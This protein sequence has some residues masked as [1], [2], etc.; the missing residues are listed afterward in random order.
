MKS[1]QV[2][3]SLRGGPVGTPF[4]LL[5]FMNAKKCTIFQDFAYTISKNFPGVIPRAPASVPG[6]W[7]QTPIS[8]GVASVPIV[9]VFAKRDHCSRAVFAEFV[10]G[11]F[12]F[13]HLERGSRRR[14]VVA[15]LRRAGRRQERHRPAGRRQQPLAIAGDAPQSNDDEHVECADGEHGHDAVQ[16]T[17]GEV[18]RGEGV[19]V[20]AQHGA[21]LE[22]RRIVVDPEHVVR[23]DGDRDDRKQTGA[24]HACATNRA[25]LY[26]HIKSIAIFIH[27][28]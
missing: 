17:L 25:Q 14:L 6:A 20:V 16:E 24:R 28:L 22:R 26:M 10:I 27:L 12:Q 3:R 13:F 5:V 15:V 21:H 1:T 4:P 19:L 11:G 8:T 18:E 2:Q 7:T 23:S 9:P